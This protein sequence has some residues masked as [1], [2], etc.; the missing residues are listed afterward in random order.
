M[1]ETKIIHITI[2]GGDEKYIKEVASAFEEFKK[3][4]RFKDVEFFITNERIE[5]HDINNL[6]KELYN[7]YKKV[8]KQE[9]QVK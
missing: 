3:Q 9:L 2:H 8:K 1:T 7:L 5:I 6:M 4:D